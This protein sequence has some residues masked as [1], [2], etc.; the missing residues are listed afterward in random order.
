MTIEN[1]NL[2]KMPYTMPVLSE[3]DLR[4]MILI[5]EGCIFRPSTVQGVTPVISLVR[6]SSSSSFPY[7]HP[8][9]RKLRSIAAN[10][11][12][13]AEECCEPLHLGKYGPG[14]QYKAHHD[15]CCDDS[16]ACLKFRERNG[17]RIGT[18]LVYLNDSFKGG[19]TSFPHLEISFKPKAG[20]AVFWT[21]SACPD[22]ALHAGEPVTEG[23]KLIATVWVR[24]QP[25]LA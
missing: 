5:T 23:T 16:E 22:W 8:V 17:D 12:G 6:T 1:E 2:I 11:F 4:D 10:A 14:E 25:F 13:V 24:G 21:S 3:V 18:M 15:S 7:T 19:H 20:H 9:T